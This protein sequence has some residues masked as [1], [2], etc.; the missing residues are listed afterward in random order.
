MN[1]H[2]KEETLPTWWRGMKIWLQSPVLLKDRYRLVSLS[3]GMMNRELC[4]LASRIAANKIN[5][6]EFIRIGC[7]KSNLVSTQISANTAKNYHWDKCTTSIATNLSTWFHLHTIPK[8]KSCS[9]NKIMRPI[10]YYTFAK[11][12]L[13]AMEIKILWEWVLLV[14]P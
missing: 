13:L 10:H 6:L 14:H 12:T 7:N 3:N 9:Q 4:L 11:A 5:I 8:G 2:L 1:S